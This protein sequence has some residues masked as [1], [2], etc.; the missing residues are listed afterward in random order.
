MPD[1]LPDKVTVLVM[2]DGTE[3]PLDDI[4]A[5]AP[6][7]LEV[8]QVPPQAFE[9]DAGMHPPSTGLWKPRPWHTDLTKPDLEELLRTAS[10]L[11]MAVPF[12]KRLYPRMPNLTWVHYA[13]A[14]ISDMRAS[15]LWGQ[16]VRVT[17]SRGYVDVLPIAETVIGATLLFAKNLNVA[18]KQTTAGRLDR[19]EYGMKFLAG[20]TMGII[21]LGGIGEH[22]ARLAKALGMRVVATRRSV[23]ERR[24]DM[25]NVDLL[26]PPAELDLLLAESDFLTL[27]PM[28]TDETRGMMNA[29]TFGQ[30][31]QGACILNVARGEVIDEAAL[32]DALR[33]GKL[34]GAYLDVYTDEWSRLPDP[35]L[36]A[37][38]TVVITPHN[39][40]ITDVG[41]SYAMDLF[42]DNLRRLLG[43]EP[44]V[45]EVEWA[46]GY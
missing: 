32:K 26:Y 37:L 1:T 30:M 33:S 20:K 17:S 41:T 35:E 9:D 42:R 34:G 31:K 14:G 12:P 2:M 38:P 21:G 24:T 40:G 44:L 25:P 28:L 39:S 36:M 5:I 18:V 16:P 27:A 19:A 6:E 4:T 46:R 7:R 45:N 43:E 13:F 11:T 10:V 8:H 22:T 23:T 15:D 3:W 29:R